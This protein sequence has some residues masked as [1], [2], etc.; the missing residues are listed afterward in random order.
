MV[1]KL[2]VGNLAY[3]VDDDLLK[4]AFEQFGTVESATVVKDRLNGRSKG[5]G[6]IEMATDESAAKALEKMNKREFEGRLMFV[7]EAMSS[8]RDSRGDGPGGRGSNFRGGGGYGGGGSRGPS[9]RN[10][11]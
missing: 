11:R 7:S 2:Y 5:F 8:G 3:S 10:D 1:K 9:H 6:F 4:E